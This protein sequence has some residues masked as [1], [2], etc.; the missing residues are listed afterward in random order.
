M[1]RILRPHVESARR[2][3]RRVEVASLDLGWQLVAE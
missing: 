3:V 2:Q 1:A